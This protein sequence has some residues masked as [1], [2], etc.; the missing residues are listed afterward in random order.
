MRGTELLDKMELI[1]PAYVEAA[2][3]KPRKR[4]NVWVRWGAMAACL[5]IVILGAVAIVP[6]EEPQP[7]DIIDPAPSTVPGQ[8]SG[9]QQDEPQPTDSTGSGLITIPDLNVG[10]MGFEGYMYYDISE[11][12]TGNPWSESMNITSL[13][14]Y[15]NRAYDVSGAGVPQG[16]SET[17]MVERLNLAVSA[18]GLEVLSQEVIANGTWY[19]KDGEKVKDDRPTRIEAE[20]NNGMIYALASG[21]ISYFQHEGW[22]LP[23]ELNFTL[24]K[25]TD[26]EAEEALSYLIEAYGEFL[27]VKEPVMVCSGDYTF[28][29]EFHRDYKVYDASGDDVEDILNYNFRPARFVPDENEGELWM[30]GITDV[31]LAAEKMGDYPIITAEE[32]TKRLING[33][34]QTSVPAEFPGEEFIGKVELMYRSGPLE[35]VLLPYYRFYVQLPDEEN[36]QAAAEK[37]L[38]TY[39]AY[40]VPAITDEYIANMPTYDGR[41]N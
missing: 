10:G 35:E 30:V 1:D 28:A 7:P 36:P 5:G 11:L 2:D 19:I 9:G 12:N 17:E 4:K 21:G 34:Y 40:Y 15:K 33:N 20:T 31:L 26:E 37:G 18:L 24:S 13:P 3:E 27:N 41:F 25:T 23:D 8:N 14:V 29:G 32:A 22:A 6:Q 38:K 39:G 16:L